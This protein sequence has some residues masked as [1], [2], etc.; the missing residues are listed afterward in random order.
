MHDLRDALRAL[1]ATPVVSAVALLS[2][3]LGIGA[4]TAMFS[5]LD[6]LLLRSLPVQQPDRLLLMTQGRMDAWTN[7]I[8]EQIRDRQELF[9]GAAAWSSQ[10][11]D[12]A[13]GG[14]TD[15]IEGLWV[16][17][18]YF[19]MLG[20]P[21]ILGR[22]LDPRDDVRGGGPAGPAAVIAY[23]FWQRRFGGAA[24][25]IGRRLTIDR[26]PFTIVGVTP[27]DFFG[28]DVGRTFDVAV[29]IGAEP[30]IR[31]KES[32]LDARSTWWLNIMLRQA[33][34]QSAGAAEQALRGI[35]PQVREATVPQQYREQDKATYLSTPVDLVPAAA[36]TS[37]LRNRY[38]RPLVT[39]MIVVSLVLLI[40]CANIANLLLARAAARRHEISV[41]VALGASRLRIV[42]QLLCES[43]LL[44]GA[45][46]AAGLLFAVWGSRLLVRQLSTSTT[47]VFLDLTIDWRVLAFTAAV[48]MLTAIVFGTAPALRATRVPPQ[49]A[50]KAGGRPG[51]ADG[52]LSPV[53]LLV[54]AQVA[55]S[56]MLVVGAGLFVRT[57][58]S[59]A[60]QDH[61][62]ESAP[63]LIAKVN[64]QR[65][66]LEPDERG[67]FFERL[68][69]AAAGV[70]GVESAAASAITPVEGAMWNT[71]VQLAGSPPLSGRDRMSYVNLVSPEWLRTYGTRLLAGRDISPADTAK[72]P[73]V[74][75]VNEAFAH[76]FTGGQ[77]PIGRRIVQRAGPRGPAVD[78]EIVG[79]VADAAYNSLRTAVPPTMYLPVAQSTDVP[80]TMSIS[81]RAAVG[82]PALLSRG[83]TTA[84]TGVNGDI[85]LTLRPL[86]EQVRASLTQE[87]LVAMLSGFFG[88]LALLLAG[89]GLYGVTAYAVSRRKSEMGIRVALGAT[90]GRVQRLV[91]GRVALLV[92]TGIALGTALSLWAARFGGTLVYGLEARDP[93]TLAV[94][95]LVLVAVGALAGGIPARRAARLDP[96]AVLRQ[97]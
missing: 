3:A 58:V 70:P 57:F 33:P 51:A 43:L 7:P 82:A 77:N 13:A 41:R 37:F 19:H 49:D 97:G 78:R 93:L 96:A 39:I 63:V 25:V 61:G 53:N 87:R 69:E 88:A 32:W 75:L 14:Q 81:V 45:G 66:Q 6:S 36:G 80:S 84:L 48:A 62:F 26:V 54:I 28:T 79:Y 95:A 4:N 59:L 5:I 68:R 42:R 47:R 83:L 29:P 20:V 89:I 71:E 50:L 9:G 64:A 11:F 23:G 15:P 12:L 40:A 56:L 21:A 92:G 31:G 16:S 74:V 24:D 10:R 55:L 85:A 30:L 2:L 72:S 52:R 34:N 46:A 8:W 65:L 22:T 35:Q 60:Y 38:E 91:L 90:P 18:D 73:P 67:P 27:P 94:A 1:R 76:R 44:A 86:D 17:G